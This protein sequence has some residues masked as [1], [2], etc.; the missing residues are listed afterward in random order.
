MVQLVTCQIVLSK[1]FHF[2]RSY[3]VR[4][5]AESRAWIFFFFFSLLAHEEVTY[6]KNLDQKNTGL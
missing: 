4:D 1:G 5:G 3:I 6:M 2:L